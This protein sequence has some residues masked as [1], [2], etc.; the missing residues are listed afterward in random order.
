[1]IH[2]LCMELRS[3]QSVLTSKKTAEIDKFRKSWLTRAET[4]KQKPWERVPRWDNLNC[5]WWVAGDSAWPSLRVKKLQRDPVIGD[6]LQY[7]KIYLQELNQRTPL[8]LLR[9]ERETI[10]FETCQSTS[11]LTRP[12]LRIN[13]LTGAYPVGVLYQSLTDLQ[14]G[15]YPTPAHS[16][17]LVPPKQGEEN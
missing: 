10:H 7:C 15:K 11:F 9:E 4:H 2:T 3:H 5:N 1:M 17:H 16:N 13:W 12:T 8:M 6:P 14:E